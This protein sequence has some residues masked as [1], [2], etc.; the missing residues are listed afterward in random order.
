MSTY[1]FLDTQ[2]SF[3]GPGGNFSV[4]SSA[5]VAEEG[6]SYA[7]DED[8]TGTIT[9]ADG[10]I[11][12]SLHASHT[13]TVTVRLLKTSPV[14][15]KLQA[16]HNLQKTGAALWGINTLAFANSTI[17]DQ[18]TLTQAAF[19]KTPDNG[20]AKDGNILEWVFRGALAIS[21]GKGALQN[22]A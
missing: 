8:Q 5:G 4:G 3:I 10:T 12:H 14:N 13:G 19:V 20:Y 18:I 7:L 15:G 21:L 1:S 17:G 22:I 11:M 9:G 2:G 16:A 6:V